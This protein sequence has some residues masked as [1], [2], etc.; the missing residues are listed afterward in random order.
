MVSSL[1][2]GK[3]GHSQMCAPLCALC[4]PANFLISAQTQQALLLS[5]LYGG[6][7]PLWE[8]TCNAGDLGSVPGSRRSSGG[9]KDYPLQYSD[10]KNPMD[11][12]SPW[13]RK[14]SDTIE[15]LNWKRL[16]PG[17]VDG[18]GSLA[19]FSPWG[20]KELDT[21]EQLN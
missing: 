15:R 19:C 11:L 14:E 18:Q 17:V 7:L 20:C 3:D 5:P 21:T 13:G 9:G 6:G 16:S 2:K 4:S 12:H 1:G 8:S 10:L